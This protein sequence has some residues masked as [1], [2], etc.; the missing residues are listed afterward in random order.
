[1]TFTVNGFPATATPPVTWQ[2]GAVVQNEVLTVSGTPTSPGSL[3]V[4]TASLPAGQ[5]GSPYSASLQASG[6]VPP[7]T[8]SLVSGSAMPPGLTL[9]ANGQISGTPTAAGTTTFTVQVADAETPPATA[10]ATLSLTVNAGTSASA[11]AITTA[12]LPGASVGSAYSVNLQATGGTPPY[13]WAVTNGSLPPGL[14]LT[15]AGVL[16]GTPTEPGSGPTF[17]TVTVTDAQGSSQSAILALLVTPSGVRP[18]AAVAFGQ[19]TNAQTPASASVG[20]VVQA[21]ASGGTGAVAVAQ[22]SANPTAV[23]PSDSTGAFYDVSLAPNSSFTTVTIQFCNLN[24]ATTIDWFNQSANQWVPASDQQFN[25]ATACVTVTVS[26]TTTPS[27]AELAGTP[28][29]AANAPV[30]TTSS[31]P[32]GQVGSSYSATLSASNGMPPYTWALAAGSQLPPGLSLSAAG[33]LS[34]TPTTPGTT[35]FT[36]QVTDSAGAT[37]TASLTLTINPPVMASGGGG[38]GGGAGSAGG[39]GGGAS[40]GGGVSPAPSPAPVNGPV[41]GTVTPASGGTVTASFANGN[42]IAV[43]VP[44]GA[45]TERT[46]VT[47]NP[48]TNLPAGVTPLDTLQAV[49]LTATP[50]AYFTQPVT[51]TWAFPTALGAL[52]VA[53]W[54]P[55]ALQWE[56]V[57]GVTIHGNAVSITTEHLTLF[58]VVPTGAL[59]QIQRV[60]GAT[61]ID[62]AIAAAETAFPDGTTAVVLANA[63]E[64]APSPDALAAAGLAGAIH[65][66]ILLTAANQLSPEVLSAIQS[67]GAKTV[68][69]VGG[70]AAV[71]DAVVTTLQQSGLTVVRAFQGSDR[72]QTAQ[73]IDNYLYQHGLSHASTVFVANGATMVDALSASPVIYRLQAPVLLVNTGQTALPAAALQALEGAGIRQAVVL[74]GPAAVLPTVSSQLSNAGLTVTQLGGATRDATAVAIDQHFF[75]AEPGGAVIAADGSH[76]GS[77]VDALSASVL[78]GSLNIPI[79]LTAPSAFPAESLQYLTAAVPSGPF[80]VMGG[81]AAINSSVVAQLP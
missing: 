10:K 77:F 43:S 50:S 16:S 71:G 41:T 9:A 58:A 36:V 42:S 19:S 24:G 57:P 80:W 1:M 45:V 47:V 5:V 70:P 13:T 31:L 81:A 28:F 39:G 59:S 14:T 17:F 11:L 73:L 8:W 26:S 25:A 69:I 51:V 37:A 2:S 3:G 56:I 32:S 49:D 22:E 6:G 12:T 44:P 76:G 78:A 67:L 7:Y 63:G 68:Y 34:G 61:R 52:T 65:G 15:S 21:T 55:L 54:N 79:V 33:T 18:P 38:G 4:V 23:S 64:G 72:F 62:T 66:P 74:G 30:V 60:A 35:T 46:T 75:P 27:L 53:Y 40:G 29:A 20:N 48:L